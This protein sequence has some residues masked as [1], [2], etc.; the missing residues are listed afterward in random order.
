[1]EHYEVESKLSDAIFGPVM[2]CKDLRH[3]NKLVA[4]KLINLAA[5]ARHVTASSHE[6]EARTVQEDNEMELA[7]YHAFAAHGGHAHVLNLHE[8]FDD[9]LGY[10]HMVLDYCRGGELYDAVVAATALSMP[11]AQRYFRQV[12][13]GL[14]FMHSC[15]FAHRDVSLENVLLDAN[16]HCK[17]ID[18]GLATPIHSTTPP[19]SSIG[20]LFYM[21]PEVYQGIPYDPVAADMWSLGVLLFI[22]VVGSPPMEKPHAEDE[23][24]ALIH[25]HG[26]RGLLAA[27]KVHDRFTTDAV[28]VLNSLLCIEP[29]RRMSMPA[30]LR[31]PFMQKEQEALNPSYSKVLDSPV[32]WTTLLQ[33]F[34]HTSLIF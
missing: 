15:G 9:D 22:M 30:L 19:T 24:Y 5:S 29:R 12:G 17:L 7:V 21:A 28:D 6:D 33:L 32:S 1:M 11:L 23:R 18:F 10:R 4:I 8:T 2:L 16:N 25:T 13:Q 34:A 27:W 14:Y 26:I 3:G 20:K 31:H